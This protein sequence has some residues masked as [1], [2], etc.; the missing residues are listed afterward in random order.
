MIPGKF[1]DKIIVPGCFGFIWNWLIIEVV[2]IF[3]TYIKSNCYFWLEVKKIGPGWKL[4]VW[5]LD[6]IFLTQNSTQKIR[7][8]WSW[9]I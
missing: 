5:N 2:W 9:L 7:H 6:I 1:Y 3:Y 8:E 4:S